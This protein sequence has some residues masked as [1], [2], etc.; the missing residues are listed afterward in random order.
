MSGSAGAGKEAV[1]LSGGGALG[2]YEIGVMEALFSGSWRG[3]N[4]ARVTASI[5][6]GTSVGSFNAAFMVSHSQKSCLDATRQLRRVWLERIAEVKDDRPN[7]IFRIRGWPGG[8]AAGGSPVD[9]LTRIGEDAGALT[10]SWLWRGYDLA[11]GGESLPNRA[12]RSINLSDLFSATPLRQLIRDEL[13]FDQILQPQARVLKIA[14]TNWDNGQTTIFHNQRN[15]REMPQKIGHSLRYLGNIERKERWRT[16][17]AST[18]I[19]SIFPRVRI[20]GD[21]FD[22]YFVDGGVTMNSPLHPAMSDASE[23][24]VIHMEPDLEVLPFGRA[25]STIETM[26]RL[27]WSLPAD[28]VKSDI[29]FVQRRRELISF[30][31]SVRRTLG[32]CNWQ[33]QVTSQDEKQIGNFM[34][35]AALPEIRLHRFYPSRP[36]GGALGLLDFRRETLIELIELGFQDCVEHDCDTNRCV[37]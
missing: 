6:T 7:G 17:L 29:D 30:A 36:L 5:F 10:A 19:P 35:L 15:P 2:A 3:G 23:L 26:E 32:N 4:G 22:D 14:A 16:V 13:D 28:R 31:T 21:G 9:F 24:Y 8:Y 20:R 27:L 18:A 34:K 11:F 33:E 1:V 25:T 37:V 12:R